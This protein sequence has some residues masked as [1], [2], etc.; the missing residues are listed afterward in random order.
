[1]LLL[2]LRLSV[3]DLPD[4]SLSPSSAALQTSQIENLPHTDSV[5]LLSSQSPT[6]PALKLERGYYNMI[7]SPISKVLTGYSSKGIRQTSTC[8]F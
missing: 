3:N 4:R 6:I 8:A 5:I 7:L 1:M 2:S